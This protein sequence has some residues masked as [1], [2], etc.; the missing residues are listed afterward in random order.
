[1]F[2]GI[3]I[4]TGSSKAV[5]VTADGRIT[6]TATVR[7][8]VSLPHPGQ[9]EFDAEG[10]WW[11]EIRDLCAQLFAHRSAQGLAGVC[12]SGMG[13]SLVVTDADFTPLRPA[14]LYGID[15]R[16]SQEILDLNEEFG[17]GRIFADCG[18][19]LSSQAVGPKLR[20]IRNHEPEVFARA[21]YWF[22]LNSFIVAK[23]TG[24]YV[25]D[26][27]SASQCDPLYDLHRRAWNPERWAAVAE[28]LPMPRLAWPAEVVGHVTAAAAEFTG[29]PAGTPVCAGS[30]D[31]WAE[32]FSAGVRRPGDLMLMYGSTMFFV[33]VLSEARTHPKLW[34]TAG[35]ERDSL[36]YAA[37]MST[38]GS[39]VTWMQHLFGDVPLEQLVA[40]AEQVPPGS[41]GLV[42][43]PYFAGE[44]TP[45]FDADARGLVTGLT[46]R[47][48]RAH[49]FRATYEGLCFGIRQIL[50]FMTAAGEPIQRLVA[51]GGGT[52]ARLWT[53]IAS[54]VTGR[55][56][57]IPEQTI[58]ASYGDALMAAIGAGAVPPETD[59]TRAAAVVEPDRR[60]AEVYGELYATYTR[61][62]PDNRE[63]M[64][65]L[66][67]IQRAGH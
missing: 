52:R 8:Q 36:T 41:E 5:L 58:G 56:Q 7:H 16:A 53:Q 35:I 31:A 57:I 17:P 32:A 18:K 21:K 24:E 50:E 60:Q 48:T 13:P 19:S 62:Y 47:H 11:A 23:L 45:V 30:V 40:E 14:I 63:H 65:A 64:H 12:V 6:D 61:L 55:E 49:L 26:H 25:Q 54:D 59:W 37:G 67:R 2:L 9:A 46:L 33:Q 34:T 51:V 38:S 15:T 1:M 42:I 44:R 22:G 29:I 27:H 4:G 10:I 43:L 20:W 3:D 39:L 28:H 66:A